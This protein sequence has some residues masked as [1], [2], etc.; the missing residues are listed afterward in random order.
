RGDPLRWCGARRLAR[1]RAAITANGLGK[2]C[3]RP[4]AS[5]P[6][7]AKLPVGVGATRTACRSDGL[8]LVKLACQA[9]F[10]IS[11][12][13]LSKTPVQG[14]RPALHGYLPNRIT[15]ARRTA[16]RQDRWGPARKPPGGRRQRSES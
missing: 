15:A 12:Y 8:L 14:H 11:F 7:G 1:R 16:Y 10:V 3:G 2:F 4:P 6:I 5:S 9:G 13:D